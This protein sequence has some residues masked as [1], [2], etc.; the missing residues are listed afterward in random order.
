MPKKTNI[1]IKISNLKKNRQ[2]RMLRN[3][4][5][6]FG[7]IVALIIK[8][9]WDGK[10]QSDSNMVFLW[11]SILSIFIV[12]TI[13]WYLQVLPVDI[14]SIH[15]EDENKYLSIKYQLDSITE[16]EEAIKIYSHQKTFDNS[17][18]NNEY[19]ITTYIKERLHNLKLEINE[20]DLNDELKLKL[21]NIS[22]STIKKRLEEENNQIK[23]ISQED[24]EKDNSL[25][26]MSK[27]S[28]IVTKRLRTEIAELSKRSDIYIILGSA[29][30]IAAGL[31]LFFTLSTPVTEQKASTTPA[32][33]Q[34]ASTAP[35]TE[36]KASIAAATEQKASAAAATEQ[37]AS[38]AA[39]TEQKASAAPATEQKEPSKANIKIASIDTLTKQDILSLIARFSLVI[40]IE[41]FAFYY[42]RLYK[43]IMVDIKFYQNEITNIEMKLLALHAVE[44]KN[45]L[46][47][48]KILSSEL[49]KTERNFVIDKNKTTI[50]IERYKQ[51]TNIFSSATEN[52]VKLIKSIK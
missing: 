46:D 38:A 31:V 9:V 40:F 30:T 10:I 18:E 21:F 2:F 41:V 24:P 16:I 27:L 7:F 12:L 48:L 33:E 49:I 25:I 13:Y 17:N 37:K 14:S 1:E 28:D 20:S 29:L 50:D 42:F 36:Q 8:G 4:T 11:L 5:I 15:D 6:F 3:I 44:D 39:A 23:K 43:N 26:R 35:A 32:T 51:D 22:L 47:T 52:L 45:D 19:K 34:K